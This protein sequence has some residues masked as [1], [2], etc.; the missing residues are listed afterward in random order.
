MITRKN[1]HAAVSLIILLLISLW[2]LGPLVWVGITSFKPQ[3]TEFRIPVEYWPQEPTLENYRTVLGPRFEIHRSMFNSVIVASGALVLGLSMSIAAA[4]AISRLRFRFRFPALLFTQIG[5]MVP[6]IIVIAPIFVFMRAA[7]LL[8]T[9]WAMIIP[10]AA[11][12]IPLSTWL[13]TSYF[14]NIPFEIEEAAVLDG[15]GPVRRI[16]SI[17]IPAAAPGIFSAGILAFLGTWGE[18]MLAMTVSIGQ[19]SV[20]TVPVTILSL[21][22]MFEL[23]WSWVAAGTVITLI[24]LTAGVLIFQRVIVSGLAASAVKN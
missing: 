12:D 15:A 13:I 19:R 17:M 9:H 23:Q 10:N 21:S 22:Q 24:P 20:E 5:G 8:S 14:T 16:I 7:G 4:Y 18:F 1:R 3:G 6:P 11:F 2:C